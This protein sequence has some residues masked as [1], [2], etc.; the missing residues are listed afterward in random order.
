VIYVMWFLGPHSIPC[1]VWIFFSSIESGLCIHKTN[2][3]QSSFIEICI[4]KQK[5]ESFYNRLSVFSEKFVKTSK[6]ISGRVPI[7][8]DKMESRVEA[9]VKLWR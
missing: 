9:E 6:L 2:K 4:Y 1:I 3:Q 7:K 8:T 5:S